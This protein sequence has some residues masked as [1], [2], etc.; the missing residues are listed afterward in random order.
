MNTN[1]GGLH[2]LISCH[3]HHLLGK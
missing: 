1:N 2:D 3:L